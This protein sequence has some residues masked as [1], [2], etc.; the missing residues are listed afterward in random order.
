MSNG[1]IFLLLKYT[2]LLQTADIFSECGLSV[3]GPDTRR[4]RREEEE[5]MNDRTNGMTGSTNSTNTTNGDDVGRDEDMTSMND[6]RDRTN[7]TNDVTGATRGRSNS[8]FSGDVSRN[9]TKTRDDTTSNSDDT[10]G[11]SDSS[12]R[13][14]ET[15][16]MFIPPGLVNDAVA[17]TGAFQYGK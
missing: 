11:N 1:C 6:G 17:L 4:K 2:Y 14:R 16:A 13:A 5:E 10:T 12:M 3:S 7:V 15:D 9:S 8:A